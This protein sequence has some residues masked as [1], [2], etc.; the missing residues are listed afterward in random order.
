M[1]FQEIATLRIIKHKMSSCIAKIIFHIKLL[2]T[3]FVV[4]D[5]W[6]QVPVFELLHHIIIYMYR[7]YQYVSFVLNILYILTVVINFLKLTCAD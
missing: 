6:R 1:F 5:K 3:E 7:Y 2:K 4:N